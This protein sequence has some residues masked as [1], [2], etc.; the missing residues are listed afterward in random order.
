[1]QYNKYSQTITAMKIFT[2]INDI[3]TKDIN[4]INNVFYNNNILYIYSTEYDNLNKNTYVSDNNAP[5]DGRRKK[6]CAW[7]TTL[8]KWA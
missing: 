1:M 5:F 6:F 3:L 8:A 2:D 7:T 4:N